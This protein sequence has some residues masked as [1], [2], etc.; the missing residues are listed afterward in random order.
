MRHGISSDVG[1]GQ[2]MAEVT[3]VTPRSFRGEVYFEVHPDRLTYQNINVELYGNSHVP[4]MTACAESGTLLAT[5][6]Y[7]FDGTEIMSKPI[8]G[9]PPLQHEFSS[10]VLEFPFYN[11]VYKDLSFECHPRSA[12]AVMGAAE[13]TIGDPYGEQAKEYAQDGMNYLYCIRVVLDPP[14]MSPR[15][16]ELGMD[17]STELDAST[18]IDTKFEIK[19]EVNSNDE[20]FKLD[21]SVRIFST[22]EIDSRESYLVTQSLQIKAFLCNIYDST[23]SPGGFQSHLYSVGQTVTIC[24]GPDEE[25]VGKSKV[26]AFTNVICENDGQSRRMVEDGETDFLTTIMQSPT[27]YTDALTGK[28]IPSTGILAVQTK[29][30]TGLIQLGDTSMEC[31]GEV[32]VQSITSRN[33]QDEAIALER[34]TRDG[35]ESEFKINVGLSSVVDLNSGGVGRIRHARW[36]LG[37]SLLASAVLSLL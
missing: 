25:S 13:F 2:G 20:N 18:F 12:N 5:S 9:A 15:Q 30:T 16:K 32:L 6:T 28:I 33:L 34:E 3:S 17:E 4:H 35:I 14:A 37:S 26:T 1:F 27:G 29:I 31:T 23:A 7:A 21:K 19:G 22:K 11:D 24:V 36:I 10:K 8:P